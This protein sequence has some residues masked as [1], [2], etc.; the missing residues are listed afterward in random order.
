[1]T[2]SEE[3][4]IGIMSGTSA[5]GVDCGL[6]DFSEDLPV[7]IMTRY[8][9]F[10]QKLQNEILTFSNNHNISIDDIYLLENTLT[11]S[12][13]KAVI[14]VIKEL[15]ISPTRIRAIGCHGQTIRHN[16][17]KGYSIQLVNGSLLAELT[18]IK[19]IVDFRSRDIAAG[20]QGAPLTPAFHGAIFGHENIHRVIVNIGGMANLTNLNPREPVTGFDTGP[21]NYLLD[22][23]VK[24][25]TGDSF[26]DKGK[27]AKSGTVNNALLKK[28]KQHD[29]LQQLP[30]KSCSNEQFN[31]AWVKSLAPK[32]IKPIDMQATL[33]EFTA[34]SIINAQKRYCPTAD[35]IYV[36]GG[37]A[38]NDFLMERLIDLSGSVL[39][40][41][42]NV[43]GIDPDWVE[44]FAFAW[45]A[46]KTLFEEPIDYSN[47]TGSKGPR[48]LG[49]IYP[50]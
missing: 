9:P 45:L 16:P 40:K 36:C 13:A 49:C 43:I 46:K 12:Y 19:A 25:M 27:W 2:S 31:L 18:N 6:I 11:K 3:L 26:D 32:L 42:T 21:G 37:G 28:L 23:Y 17:D 8:F 44:A 35:E 41:K 24:V 50:C 10:S 39:L 7:K 5:D 20:G 33:L 15:N 4:F 30:P 29:F 38:K 47:V 22:S 48:I 14:S 34:Q 1:M